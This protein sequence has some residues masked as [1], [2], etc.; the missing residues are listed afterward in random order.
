MV[1]TPSD[2]R[3]LVIELLRKN[4]PYNPGEAPFSIDHIFNELAELSKIRRLKYTESLDAWNLNR[5][6]IPYSIQT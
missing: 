4:R 1:L 6:N 2:L 5:S 3:S